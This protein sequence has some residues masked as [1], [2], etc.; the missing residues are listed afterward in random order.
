MSASPP[1][2]DISKASKVGEEV[3]RAKQRALSQRG[4]A[5]SASG[6]KVDTPPVSRPAGASNTGDRPGYITFNREGTHKVKRIKNP[7]RWMRLWH[8][9]MG[10]LPDPVLADWYKRGQQ[11][12]PDKA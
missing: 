11:F 7:P 3:V 4:A 12:V 6:T 8:D 2:P 1:A 9:R 10:S 5:A